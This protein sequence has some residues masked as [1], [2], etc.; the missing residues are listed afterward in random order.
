MHVIDADL[1]MKTVGDTEYLQEPFGVV[2]G[3]IGNQ[4]SLPA[5]KL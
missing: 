4:P 5:Q 3:R 2:T 1:A